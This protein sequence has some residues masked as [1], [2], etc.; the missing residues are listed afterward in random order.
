MG[1]NGM[2]RTFRVHEPWRSLAAVAALMGGLVAL[3]RYGRN[4]LLWLL[5]GLA[6]LAFVV[7]LMVAVRANRSLQWA[8]SGLCARCLLG[9]ARRI[10]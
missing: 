8:T 10:V 9:A 2:H 7:T 3:L 1:T 6:L 4:A 5:T